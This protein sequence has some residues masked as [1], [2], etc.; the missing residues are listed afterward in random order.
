MINFRRAKVIEILS[1]RQG[2]EEVKVKLEAKDSTEIALNYS[3]L[4]GEVRVGDSVV[5][6]TTA[7]DL[8]L[9]TGER[10]FILWNFTKDKKKFD[11]FINNLS[12]LLDNAGH[13]MKLRYTPFQFSCLAVEEEDSPY[14]QGIKEEDNLEG[15]PV[16]IGTLHS[17]LPAVIATA[18]EIKKELKIAYIMTDAAA[19]PLVFSNLVEELKRLRLL[20]ATITVGN[21]FG[22]D[23]EA[24][25]IYTGLICAKKVVKADLAVA[26][27][28]PGIA[29]TST[30]LGFSGIEQGE[31]INA[32][33]ALGGFPIAIPRISFKDKRRRH[34]GVSHHTLTSL[35]L[36]ALA[37]CVVPI[38][39]MPK[40]KEAIILNQLKDKGID[41]KHQV[42][43]VDNDL[44]EKVFLKYGLKVTTMGRSYQEEPEFFQAAGAAGIYAVKMLEKRGG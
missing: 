4:T 17:Q 28:G 30:K 18:K 36:V 44:T 41:T 27:M 20:E 34:Q 15:M 29:G 40:N 9:G 7:V 2:L 10:H 24:I 39:K 35:S 1:Q 12:N 5:I 19:L 6:N 11:S 21:A 25:N 3:S 13:I 31:I 16:V 26:I 23:Y 38:P 22:G 42:E 33:Y 32:V 14:Y 43:V 37:K 8:A